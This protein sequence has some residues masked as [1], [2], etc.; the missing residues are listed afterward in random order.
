MKNRHFN[1]IATRFRRTPGAEMKQVLKE[2]WE[3][4]LSRDIRM[5]RAGFVHL[6]IDGY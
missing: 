4:V 5:I 2:W 6:I 3:P 1:V